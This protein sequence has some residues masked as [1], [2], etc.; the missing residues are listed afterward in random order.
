MG[1]IRGSQDR[2][3]SKRVVLADVPLHRNFLPKVTVLPWQK[4]AMI[5]DT[6]T[7]VDSPKLPFYENTLFG[8]ALK[9]RRRRRAEKR[10]SKRVFLESPFLL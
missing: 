9:E 2:V 3:V 4:K 8:G 7:R 1:S 10:L 5:F 6:E